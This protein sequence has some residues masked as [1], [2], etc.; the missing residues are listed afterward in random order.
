MLKAENFI[1]RSKEQVEE[2]ILNDV[3]PIL[4]KYKNLVKDVELNV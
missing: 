3:N 4:E 1:G 2:F